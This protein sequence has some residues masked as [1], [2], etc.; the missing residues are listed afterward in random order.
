[1]VEPQEPSATD[2]V[3]KIQSDYQKKFNEL[4]PDLPAAMIAVAEQKII[5]MDVLKAQIQEKM[6]AINE[7]VDDLK[8]L[9]RENTVNEVN[10]NGLLTKSQADYFDCLDVK[11]Q[12]L[13]QLLRQDEEHWAQNLEMI[14]KR[15]ADV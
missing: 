15:A 14:K 7:R 13:E 2:K 8:N 1:M 5:G 4:S 6:A 3:K 12:Q 9:I 11:P 10:E